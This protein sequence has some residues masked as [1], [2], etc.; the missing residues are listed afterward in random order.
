MAKAKAIPKKDVPGIIQKRIEGMTLDQIAAEEGLAP[1]TI[2]NAVLNNWSEADVE[3]FQK[4]KKARYA[5]LLKQQMDI[6]EDPEVAQHNALRFGAGNIVNLEKAAMLA[7]GRFFE[8][9]Q[10]GAIQV[11]INNLYI[12]YDELERE[13]KALMGGSAN[14]ITEG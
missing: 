1:S 13:K 7:E 9:E 14:A 10:V 5:S 2:R 11:N 8:G 6:Q 12:K 4:A 3:K